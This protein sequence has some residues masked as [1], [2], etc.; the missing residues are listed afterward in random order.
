[1]KEQTQIWII[2]TGFCLAISALLSSVIMDTYLWFDFNYYVP[3][4]TIA[5][6]SLGT[7]LL[8]LVMLFFIMGD[9]KEK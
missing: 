3:S 4:W 5:L 2:R 1:M 7:I 8:I 6:M 9:I